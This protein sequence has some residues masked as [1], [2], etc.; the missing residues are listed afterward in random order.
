MSILYCRNKFTNDYVSINDVEKKPLSKTSS[1]YICLECKEPLQTKMGKV[2]SHH[3]SH[4]GNSKCGGGGP[5]SL[6]HILGKE[7]IKKYLS[8]LRFY[9]CSEYKCKKTISFTNHTCIIEYYHKSMFLDCGIFDENGKL[10]YAIEI[11]HKHQVDDR[12]LEKLK[13]CS[14]PMKELVAKDMLYSCYGSR[15]PEEILKNKLQLQENVIFL[16]P[17][18]NSRCDSCEL[19]EQKRK[20]LLRLRRLEEEEDKKKKKKMIR[21]Q[22][23]KEKLEKQYKAFIRDFEYDEQDKI[24]LDDFYIRNKLIQEE[25]KKK[26]IREGIE[27]EQRK[28]RELKRKE[29]LRHFWFKC[30]L[31][32]FKR[33]LIRNRTRRIEKYVRM[34]VKNMTNVNK[35][36]RKNKRKLKSKMT[37]EEYDWKEYVKIQLQE[38]QPVDNYVEKKYKAF[39]KE[40]KKNHL[41][42]E[43]IRIRKTGEPPIYPGYNKNVNPLCKSSMSKQGCI[44][45]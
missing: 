5:E 9:D 30:K 7:T 28:Q 24:D 34:F 13:N 35:R 33:K 43:W 11:Y 18:G 16:Q 29:N 19:K 32:L 6:F 25:F 31:R 39:R 4:F 21:D 8:K 12:K 2:L 10:V 15:D 42:Y 1:P 17:Y 44:C 3:F 14:L 40:R 23:R 26:M 20:E 37:F 22:K 36:I 38:Q 27:K 41:Y 45:P